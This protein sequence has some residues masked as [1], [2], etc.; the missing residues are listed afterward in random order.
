MIQALGRRILPTLFLGLTLFGTPA[1]AQA[2]SPPTE[3]QPD[4]QLFVIHYRPGPAW[5]AGR[6][7]GEQNLRPHG[8]YYRDLLQQGRVFAGGGFVGEDGGLAIIRAASRAEAE[9]ILA[10]DPA[11][12]D[13]IFAAELRQWSPR[14]VADGPLAERP[15]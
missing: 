11:I 1:A 9:A 13:G 7:M 8:L 14:F 10:A 6:P 12:R 15:R 4:R 3:A 5:V 2:P